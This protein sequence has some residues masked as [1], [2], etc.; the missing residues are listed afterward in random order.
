MRAGE[1][2]KM[3]K[4]AGDFVTLREVVDEVGVDAVRFMM[5]YPQER[6]AARLRPRQGDRAVEGQSGLLC[7]IRPCPGEIGAAA[8]ARR[9]SRYRPSPA[10]SSRRGAARSLDR[11]RRACAGQDDRAISARLSKRRRRRMSRTASPSICTNWRACSMPIGPEAARSAT[12]TFY[13]AR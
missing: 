1:P 13:Y 4:R 12:I 9:L 5:L 2:V 6:R 11:R 8:G 3:S 7:P 10:E